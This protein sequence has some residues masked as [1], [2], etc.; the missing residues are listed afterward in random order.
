MTEML[1][2]HSVQEHIQQLK[3]LHPDAPPWAEMMEKAAKQVVSATRKCNV[4]EVLDQ[5]S[6]FSRIGDEYV[7]YDTDVQNKAR[8]LQPYSTKAIDTVKLVRDEVHRIVAE[9]LNNNCSCQ[10]AASETRR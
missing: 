8:P 1:L 2:S 5:F 3:S 9:T 4:G 7:K 6:Y 10:V